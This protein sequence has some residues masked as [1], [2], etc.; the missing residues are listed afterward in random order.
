MKQKILISRNV[1]K[2]CLAPYEEEF[3][4]TM[5]EET[6]AS[7][8]LAHVIDVIGDYEGYFAVDLQAPPALFDAA[9][10]LKAIANFGVGYDKIDWKYATKL[11]IPLLNTPTQV[12]ES[13][14]ELATALIM[15]TMRGVS[16]YDKEV[17]QNVWIT[18][19]FSDRNTQLFGST[20]GIV[21]FG[22][23]G[24]AV[25]KKAQGLGMKVVY[26]DK[27]RAAAEVEKAYDVE[28]MDFEA[29]LGFCDCV[30]LH[31]PY[32][33]EN[34]HIFNAETFKKMKPGAYF[35]NA[36]RGKLVD[37]PALCEA[38]KNGV[39]KG[40][41]LDV[42]ENEPTVYEGLLTLDNVV[43]TPHIASLTMRSR[44][45]MCDEALQGLTAI[46]NGK[47]PHNVVNPE[48]LK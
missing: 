44:M 1:P 35:V 36:A 17:R 34:H 10:K 27:Y 47:T 37:E 48:V 2:A 13:T 16:R 23:I 3:D 19:L 46:L 42:Y 28:Y 43:L 41:G 26:Y 9:K 30:S 24:K 20:L 33:P 31:A 12:T 45:G 29:L 7:F 15:D 8:P 21:G 18:P 38:L 25:C 32:F 11:G 5:P 14:A 4:F 39:I 40:A 6:D 22:R